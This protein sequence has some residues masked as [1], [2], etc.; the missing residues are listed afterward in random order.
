MPACVEDY[1]DLSDDPAGSLNDEAIPSGDDGCVVD[2]VQD[3]QGN[4][5][6]H[7][8]FEGDWRFK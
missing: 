5:T 2:A 3:W 6:W 7:V 8:I 4:T 1:Q